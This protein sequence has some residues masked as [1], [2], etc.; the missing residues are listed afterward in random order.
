MEEI[1][2]YREYAAACVRAAQE[3][4]SQ[5]VKMAL[6]DMAQ[7]WLALADDGERATRATE[8]LADIALPAQAA[9]PG[10]EQGSV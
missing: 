3:V 5:T 6:L 2:R 8:R 10:T 4:A 7:R 9:G 1:V